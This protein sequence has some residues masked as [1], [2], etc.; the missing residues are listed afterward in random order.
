MLARWRRIRKHVAIPILVL[1]I[2]LIIYLSMSVY[3][4]KDSFTFEVQ[5]LYGDRSALEDVVIRG[6]LGDA[7]HSL[8]FQVSEDREEADIELF[9][10]P[11]L[12]YHS[13][14][15]H[16]KVIEDRVYEVSEYGYEVQI[17]ERKPNHMRISIPH[18]YVTGRNGQSTY[19]NTGKYGLA[20]VN[21]D[22][23][24]VVPS[25]MHYKGQNGIYQLN[26]AQEDPSAELLVPLDMSANDAETVTGIEVLGLEV[27]GDK[28]AL[29]LTENNHKLIIRGYDRH[30][31]T[32]LGEA[33]VE[34]FATYDH[35][36][37]AN[38]EQ[39]DRH[40]PPFAA[41]VNE[42][43]MRLNLA[44]WRSGSSQE[45]GPSFTLLSFD[46]SEDIRLLNDVRHLFTEGEADSSLAEFYGLRDFDSVDDRLIAVMTVREPQE[47]HGI[48]FASARPMRLMIYVFERGEMVYTGEVVTDMNDDLIRAINERMSFGYDQIEHRNVMSIDILT[49]EP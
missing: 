15:F 21:D 47:E 25:T 4:A 30:D 3:A 2:G 17:T 19:V 29:I 48:P 20:G 13:V 7:Y 36:V 22:L 49:N 37:P 32:T 42:D 31:G 33:A 28:L 35:P 16:Q 34:Q 27:V 45:E 11:R 8:Y 46:L 43:Q 5:D 41:F 18:Y 44:F 26:L 9:D 6:E 14:M 12:N 40:N 10:L 38:V 1:T 39:A 24:Y 23:Y